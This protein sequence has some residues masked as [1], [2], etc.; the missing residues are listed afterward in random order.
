MLEWMGQEHYPPQYLKAQASNITFDKVRK[1]CRDIPRDK[2]VRL[3]ATRFLE[4]LRQE[5]KCF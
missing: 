3:I 2:R 5:K 4:F 1:Q